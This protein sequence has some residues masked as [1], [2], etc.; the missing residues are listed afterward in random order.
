MSSTEVISTEILEESSTELETVVEVDA[1]ALVP[2]MEQIAGDVR[3]I[4]TFTIIAFCTSCFRSWRINVTG[5][6]K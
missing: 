1:A 6:S 3:V 2:Y 5:G 4:L